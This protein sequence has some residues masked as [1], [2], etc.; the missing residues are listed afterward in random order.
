MGLLPQVGRGSAESE[1]ALD[2]FDAEQGRLKDAVRVIKLA[3]LDQAS[4]IERIG[5]AFELDQPSRTE[6][7]LIQTLLDHPGS[8]CAELS[9][10]HGWEET[11]WDMQ[12][13]IMCAKRQE[14]L[15][16]LEPDVREELKPSI[17]MLT[18]KKRG[19]DGV[20]RYTPK[21]EAVE[22]FRKLGFRVKSQ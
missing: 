21:P 16:P 17:D 7:K 14:Y 20:L 5:I 19:E 9:H 3:D 6:D 18:F 4:P 10:L 11:A 15:W 12:Y 13:G 1:V 22:A 8:T 2:A